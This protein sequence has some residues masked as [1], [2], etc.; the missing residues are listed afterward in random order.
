MHSNR[1]GQTS[2]CLQRHSFAKTNLAQ[3]YNIVRPPHMFEIK[4]T[5]LD[6]GRPH[7]KTACKNRAFPFRGGIGYDFS[8][9]NNVGIVSRRNALRAWDPD[10]DAA[11]IGASRSTR[12]W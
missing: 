6:D 4:D 1:G 2:A 11:I 8:N 9:G 3:S 12:A 7:L 10:I 5:G